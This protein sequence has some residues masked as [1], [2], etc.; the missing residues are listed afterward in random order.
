MSGWIGF[1][2][3]ACEERRFQGAVVPEK[4]RRGRLIVEAA[5]VGKA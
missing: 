1:G 2:A 3:F 4:R 5:F